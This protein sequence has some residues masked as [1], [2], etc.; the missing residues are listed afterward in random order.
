MK[1]G[2]SI[3]EV[4]CGLA[5]LDAIQHQLGMLLC[6][7]LTTHFKAVPR[8]CLLTVS[9]AAPTQLF[10]LLDMF[11]RIHETSPLIPIA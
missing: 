2:F 9:P 5:H 4:G 1:R 11:Y 3:H 6:N 7:M 10:A 8:K